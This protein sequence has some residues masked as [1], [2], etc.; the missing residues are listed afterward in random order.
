MAG[1]ELS[2]MSP[3]DAEAALRSYPR[4]YRE[5]FVAGDGDDIDEIAHRIGPDGVS[6]VDV[7]TDLSRT[8]ALLRDGVNRTVTAD[9]PVLH[10]GVIDPAERIWPDGP[11]E[12]VPEALELLAGEAEAFAAQVGRVP[13]EGW[14]REASIADSTGVGTI[15]AL[16]LLREAVR[17]GHD[18]LDQTTGILAAVRS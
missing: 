18:G 5:L 3:G 14:T 12:P 15:S 16:D 11:P 1:L 4:R 13:L 9:T 8:W 10:A 2:R 6:A 7:L 17:I